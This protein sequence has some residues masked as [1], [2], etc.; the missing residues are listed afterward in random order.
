[1]DGWMDPEGN[2]NVCT[3][4]GE[5]EC[6]YQMS[7]QS[8]QLL[9]RDFNINYKCEPHGGTGEKVRGSPKSWKF[10]FRGSPMSAPNFKA[11]HKL[12]VKTKP[13]MSTCWWHM[14]KSQGIIKASRIQPLET[15]HVCTKCHGNPSNTVVVEIFQS[16]THWWTNQL[17]DI[18]VWTN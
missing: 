9:L 5:H 6:M 10:I 18:A 12:V 16:G 11:I 8:I 7:W 17:P 4:W 14:K 2:T 1:M 13:K 3:K 15:I